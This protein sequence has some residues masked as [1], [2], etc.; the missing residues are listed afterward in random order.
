MVPVVVFLMGAIVPFSVPPGKRRA[1]AAFLL[2]TH[3]LNKRG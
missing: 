1:V 2:L 3:L